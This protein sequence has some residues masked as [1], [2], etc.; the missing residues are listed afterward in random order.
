MRTWSSW[1]AWASR[2]SISVGGSPKPIGTTMLVPGPTRLRT[3]VAAWGVVMV[4]SGLPLV[5]TRQSEDVLAQERQDHVV[6]DGRDL[7]DTGLAELAFDVVF[8]DEPIA[9]M[10]VEAD[11]GGLPTG[12]GGD[13]FGGVGLRATRAG[14]IEQR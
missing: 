10:D 9:A 7:V 11:V 3:S 14:G 13:E 8:V 6:V 1:A 5:G 12:L 4:I 2:V